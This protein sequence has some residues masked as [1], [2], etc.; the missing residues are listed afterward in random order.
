MLCA[1]RHLGLRLW[2][3]LA[4]SSVIETCVLLAPGLPD[5]LI[6]FWN[7]LGEGALGHG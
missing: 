4:R 5:S 7:A 2:P 1:R 3:W 6:R